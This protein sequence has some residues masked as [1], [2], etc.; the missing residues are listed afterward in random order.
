MLD[1]QTVPID[2]LD[3]RRRE[4]GGGIPGGVKGRCIPGGF[5]AAYAEIVEDLRE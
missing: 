5:I 4:D 2:N 3:G 1:E